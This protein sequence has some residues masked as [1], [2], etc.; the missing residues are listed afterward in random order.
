MKA[1]GD[2]E[3]LRAREGDCT[4]ERL[5]GVPRPARC[6]GL[7]LCTWP[8][9]SSAPV[10]KACSAPH[11]H[12]T[13]L[14]PLDTPVTPSGWGGRR[15][16]TGT[17]ASFFTCTP[18]TAPLPTA[19]AVGAVVVGSAVCAADEPRPNYVGMLTDRP[20]TTCHIMRTLSLTE[21]HGPRAVHDPNNIARAVQ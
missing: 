17:P 11:T 2:E 19:G 1:E 14:A 12:T 7:M 4:C 13:T 21:T 5:D 3:R 16:G 18:D 9:F 6:A 20:S 15:S 8:F 10:E